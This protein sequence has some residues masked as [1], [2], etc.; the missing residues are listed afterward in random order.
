VLFPEFCFFGIF[1]SFAIFERFSRRSSGND[2]VN[3]A[4][5]YL[6]FVNIIYI[7]HKTY[8]EVF[9]LAFAKKNNPSTGL[10]TTQL[11]GSQVT[12]SHFQ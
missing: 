10:S 7:G 8:K 2:D 3:V 1:S 5:L 6:F 11:A 12:N 9:F 4:I